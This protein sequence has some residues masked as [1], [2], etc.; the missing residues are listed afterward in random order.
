MFVAR[1]ELL[2]IAVFQSNYQVVP[3]SQTHEKSRFLSNFTQVGETGSPSGM[4]FKISETRPSTSTVRAAIELKPGIGNIR[5]QLVFC[6]EI[7][8][9]PIS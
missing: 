8:V 3:L 9:A 2:L 4:K 7:K 5:V 6:Y 1:V